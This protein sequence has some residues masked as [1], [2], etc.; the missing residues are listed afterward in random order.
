MVSESCMPHTAYGIRHIHEREIVKNV[1][2]QM[3]GNLHNIRYIRFDMLLS[4]NICFC[5]TDSFEHLNE[6]GG[7]GARK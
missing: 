6:T 3:C 1:I 4:D 2:G 5:Q 7:T